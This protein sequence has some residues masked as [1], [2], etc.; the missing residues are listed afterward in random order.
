MKTRIL[1][2]RLLPFLVLVLAAAGAAHAQTDGILDD[3]FSGDGWDFW[4]P[5][6]A[7]GVKVEDLAVRPDGQ[8]AIT[9]RVF[10]VGDREA[11]SCVRL[12]NGGGGTCV[13]LPFDLGGGNNNDG[14]GVAVQSDNRMILVGDAQ[15]PVADPAW[16]A[17]VTRMTAA[18]GLDNSFN[19][20]T[21]AFQLGSTYDVG[22]EAVAVAADKIYIAGSIGVD[23]GGGEVG[24]DFFVAVRKADGT[25]ETGWSGDG[26]N[27]I[28]FDL[29]A[30]GN[31]Y[32][33]AIAVDPL[34]RTVVAGTASDGVDIYLAIARFTVDGAYDGNW[35]GDGRQTVLVDLGGNGNLQF[36]GMAVDRFSRVV[37][38]G[39]VPAATG[40]R[41]VVVRLT[42]TGALDSSFGGS[43]GLADFAYTATNDIVS[44]VDVVTLSP[45]SD[46]IAILGDYDPAGTDP[47]DGFVFVLTTAGAFDGTFNHT[48]KR[49]FA[50]A[51]GDVWNHA[52]ALAVQ[53]GRLVVLGGYHATTASVNL[54]WLARLEVYLIFGDDFDAGHTGLWSTVAP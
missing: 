19:G 39:V 31:D 14:N 34:G 50:P 42:A 10:A 4:N 18:N 2:A 17:T 24:S 44:V 23:M 7:T 9:G 51:S 29:G 20:G 26:L 11:L 12:A 16:V 25:P 32:V 30:T 35:S 33:G 43:D 37:L 5:S 38:A 49:A 54:A 28:G 47:S 52:Q 48:G 3:T 46:R 13:N 40:S 6:F 53:S 36:G 45:P 41:L 27:T 21:G 8:L 22:A 1:P 15:G